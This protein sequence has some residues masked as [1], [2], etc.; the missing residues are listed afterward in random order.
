MEGERWKMGVGKEGDRRLE[1]I[2]RRKEMHD[3][4]GAR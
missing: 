2:D 3:V 4:G 1:I